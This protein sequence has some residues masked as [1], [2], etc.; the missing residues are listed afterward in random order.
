[1]ANHA[2]LRIKVGPKKTVFDVAFDLFARPAG[3]RS[4]IP[5]VRI[6]AGRADNISRV[7]NIRLIVKKG[8]LPGNDFREVSPF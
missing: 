5:L 8:K 4:R 3:C 6:V 1:V 7:G 2:E